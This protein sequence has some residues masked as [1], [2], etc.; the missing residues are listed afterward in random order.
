MDHHVYGTFRLA[1]ENQHASQL[2]QLPTELRVKILRMLLRHDDRLPLGRIWHSLPGHVGS[3]CVELSSQI[4]SACQVLYGEAY[5][6][7][8]R[9]NIIPVGFTRCEG[10]II[11]YATILNATAFTA[12]GGEQC[13]A[14]PLRLG[15][16]PFDLSHYRDLGSGKFADAVTVLARFK[17]V[18]IT[19]T[20]DVS[21]LAASRAL[22]TRL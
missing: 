7:L 5:H 4:L 20:G 10:T 13:L 16:G 9:E 21:Y 8:Y 6:V 3:Y 14:D 19:F 2:V 1:Q 18:H 17:N 12:D 11:R 15:R 22:A